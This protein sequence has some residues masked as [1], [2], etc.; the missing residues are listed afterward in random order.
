MNSDEKL[1]GKLYCAS[2][3]VIVVISAAAAV[4]KIC[5]VG[6]DFGPC[7]FYAATGYYCCG[8]GGT[9]AFSALL[10][11]N[12]ISALEYNAFVPYFVGVSAVFLITQTLSVLT[13]GRIKGMTLRPVWFIA[14]VSILILQC[15]VKNLILFLGN[16]R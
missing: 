15:A 11:G 1:S 16:T 4:M 10:R 9:R 7:P 2:L 8:C 14:G 3:I 5:G 6:F 12:I 13:R